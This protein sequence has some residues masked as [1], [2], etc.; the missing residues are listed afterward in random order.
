M[1]KKEP[2]TEQ[3]QSK[4]STQ[5]TI[6][7]PNFQEIIIPIVGTSPFVQLR[8]GKKAKE[9]MK[10]KM[11]VSIGA[12]PT[13]SAK[14]QPRQFE[15]EF[16]EA[17]YKLPDGSRGIPATSFRNAAISACKVTGYP[18][19][20]AKMSV[21][22]LADGYDVDEPSIPL[23]KIQ[24][25]DPEVLESTVRNATGVA[26]IRTRALWKNWTANLRVSFDAD[27]FQMIDVLNLFE[28]A[29]LQVGVGEGRPDSKNSAGQ[30]WGQFTVVKTASSQAA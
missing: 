15:N 18:M 5:V 30:G 28:R 9:A 16:E 6:S 2:V 19:T 11:T 3:P 10:E 24:T 20:R 22:V 12:R 4:P 7:K 13:R 8:F 21:F 29:G 1:A 25:G 23:V 14:R 17:M 27:Q 26:D